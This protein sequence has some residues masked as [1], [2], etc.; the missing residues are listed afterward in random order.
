[1][2]APGNGLL[3]SRP[4]VMCCASGVLGTAPSRLACGAQDLT[5]ENAQ[6]VL[7][8]QRAGAR[9]SGA[10]APHAN[11]KHPTPAQE[12]ER[13]RPSFS[14]RPAASP[15]ARSPHTPATGAAKQRVCESGSAV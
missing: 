6:L 10:A 4:S 9:A 5:L 13:A 1:M 11:T 3:L 15:H 7:A 12:A 14:V 2:G 8:Q